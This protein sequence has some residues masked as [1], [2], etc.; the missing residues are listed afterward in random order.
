M[1]DINYNINVIVVYIIQLC[2]IAVYIMITS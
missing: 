1:T 2:V